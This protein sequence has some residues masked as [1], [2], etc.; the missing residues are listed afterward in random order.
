MAKTAELKQKAAELEK[1]LAQINRLTGEDKRKTNR[2][3]AEHQREKRAFA[4]DVPV[5]VCADIERRT[6]LESDDEEWL[7]WYFSAD[8]GTQ[9]AFTYKFTSQQQTMIAAIRNAIVN[10]EDQAL[11]ATRG[12]GKTTYFERLLLKYTL[13]GIVH[14]SVLFASTGSAAEDSLAS[15]KAEIEVNDKLRDD[16]PEVCDPVRALE[17]TPS[18]AHYQTVTGKRH[19][20]GQHYTQHPSRFTWCGQEIY[21]PAVP[22][23]P[24]AGS[25]IA[26]RGLDSAVRGLKKKGRRPDIVGIDDPDTEDSARSEE[27]ADKIEKR[28]DRSLAALGSQKKR[29]ARVMLTTL[30]SRISV[31]YKYT[32]PQQ[33]PSW[34]GKRFKF[35]IEPPKR[36]NLWDEYTTL[37]QE[38]WRAGTNKA[39]EF[40][41]TNYE[42]MNDGA[43][44]ANPNRKDAS[45]L[46]A[47]QFYFDQVAR[48]GLESVLTEYQND[49]PQEETDADRLVLTSHHIQHNRLSG[50]EKGIVPAD[51]V[52]LTIGA[53]IRK[54]QLHWVA[55]AW[56]ANGA[57]VIV[58]YGIFD[59]GTEGRAAADCELAILEG[60]WAWHAKL[61]EQPF[62]KADGEIVDVDLCLIDMGWKEETWNTQPVATFCNTLDIFPHRMM[63]T[64]MPSKGIP[65]YRRPAASSSILIGDNCH[66]DL[67]RSKAKSE[68]CFVA[69]NA[70]HWKLKVHEG[71]LVPN[72][73]P[74]SLLLFDHTLR[75]GHPNRTEHLA[76]S[77]HIL[78]ET[79]ATKAAPGF[80]RPETRWWSSK[81]PNHYFDATYQAV[82]ARSVRGLNPLTFAAT[83]MPRTTPAPP[84]PQQ[85]VE[86]IREPDRDIARTRRRLDF[87][88][89]TQ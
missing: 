46:T 89:R 73:E 10:G 81:K 29:V 55:I 68:T 85:P 84:K 38:D 7:L 2:K 9:D 14:F 53:D 15:I 57:G 30:Q 72:G 18:R 32:D 44:P 22:G 42:D 48:I 28:I 62:M 1:T 64:F 54:T 51:A 34:H 49:P 19:D 16:Y 24:S 27:Q 65:N 17:H 23:S 37:R 83:P 4:K 8:S 59:F 31:S 50:T 78:A 20:N 33:K 75:D 69:M 39:H 12:E 66:M 6:L 41:V 47:I 43:V 88:R 74:G 77:K 21:F 11:A 82:V 80:R 26:T 56:S 45:N 86:T 67:D 61:E 87:R 63:R 3:A 71:L 76:F 5:S 70:D 13:Q 40:Y 52:M 58:D 35:L 79:W 60:L 25:I 36:M